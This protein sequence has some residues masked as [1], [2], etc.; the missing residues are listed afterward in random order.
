M[1]KP[2]LINGD[3]VDGAAAREVINPA[4]GRPFVAVARAIGGAMKPGSGMVCVNKPLDRPFDIPFGGARQSGPGRRRG[5]GPCGL[6][7]AA[8]GQRGARMNVRRAVFC[9]DRS[10]WPAPT[11]VLN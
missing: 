11:R 6:S 8:W 7:P 2:M 10:G 4:T 5:R 1:D 9:V 3:L